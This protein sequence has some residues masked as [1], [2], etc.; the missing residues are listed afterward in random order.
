LAYLYGV[1]DY[2]DSVEDE[3]L[4]VYLLRELTQRFPNLW[5]RV[6]DADGQF[7][8]VEAANV[9]P[10]W[11]N[12][13]IDH[14]R[15]WIQG[16]KLRIIPVMEGEE[17]S[18]YQ[19][20]SLADAVRFISSRPDALIHSEFIEA[21]A[22]YRLEKY[23]EQIIQSL[24][25]S[26]VTIPRKLAYILHERP[27]FIAPAV[28]AFYLRNPV[29]LKAILS[30]SSD[31]SFPPQ[32]LVTVTVRF[33][34]VL[35]AQVKSQQFSAPPIWREAL[36][37]VQ[38]DTNSGSDDGR[39]IVTRWEMGMKLTCGFEI[40]AV[41][42]HKSDN[43]ATRELAIM[44]DDLKEDG[45]EV[46]PKDEVIK[47]WEEAFRDDDE[48][49]MDINYEDFE[50]ELQGKRGEAGAA[51]TGFG[52]ATAQ[53]D[54][55][56]IVSRLEAFLNDEDAGLEGAEVDAMDIDSDSD[57]GDDD[58]DLEDSE[59]EDKE[60]SF[61]ERDFARMMR[62]MMGM[63]PTGAD[64]PSAEKSTNPKTVAQTK[65]K[66]SE[67]GI[68]AD[69]E[70]KEEEEIRNLMTQMEAEL[71]EHG[72]L[73]LDPTPEKI[74][75]LKGK[76]NERAANKDQALAAEHITKG[77]SGVNLDGGERDQDDEAESADEEV[78]VDYALAKNLLESFKSQGGMAGPASNILGMLGIQLPR[79]EDDVDGKEKDKV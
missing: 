33:T 65:D 26:M 35:F 45:D 21:E 52:D 31:L 50:R 5:V 29:A 62:E 40:M 53:A 61:D 10:K 32:D 66:H 72:V 18:K 15:V 56:K 78:D 22:F 64:T 71:N 75:A 13:E 12:P 9:V 73:K 1:T 58:D 25:H 17:S 37:T 57:D 4:V 24:H 48:G 8:L 6:F 79:D 39:K 63:P 47:S 59:D 36:Q 76:G 49:W 30:G 38:N 43:R 46:L 51:G 74:A 54:L 69:E 67:A 28:E 42:A 27:K 77:M 2:G 20:P 11:L 16:G 60:V 23:P 3:W 41:N 14:N 55:R 70:E 34:K 7:L 44:L 68:E 19:T